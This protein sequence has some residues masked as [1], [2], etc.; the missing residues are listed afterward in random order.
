GLDG[1]ANDFSLQRLL[2]GLRRNTRHFLPAHCS[3]SIRE[4]SSLDASCLP[5]HND[6]GQTQRITRQ[7]CTQL[8]LPRWQRQIREVAT[9][10]ADRDDDISVG[11]VAE[12]E[13]AS[14]SGRRGKRGSPHGHS[15]A[16][17]RLPRLSV[18]YSP[19]YCA[20]LR[21]GRNSTKKQSERHHST[22]HSH[23][24]SRSR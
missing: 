6:V 21:D 17:E 10:P 11:N 5:G 12:R 18:C 19:G 2:H 23:T 7:N 13:P 14:R 8:V 4:I 3:H 15:G 24:T 9:D 20:R 22:T 16:L 1:C